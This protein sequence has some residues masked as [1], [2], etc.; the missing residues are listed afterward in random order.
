MVRKDYVAIAGV[1]SQLREDEPGAVGQS[2][3]DRVAEGIADHIE[4]NDNGFD[5]PRF[6]KAAGA[7]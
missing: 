3:L 5:R 7:A 2:L 4:E 1:I 6:L